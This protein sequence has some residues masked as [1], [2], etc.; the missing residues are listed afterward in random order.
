[1]NTDVQ[2]CAAVHIRELIRFLT[3]RQE[4]HK[5]A[6]LIDDVYTAAADS[7]FTV[8]VHRRSK[9]VTFFSD[10]RKEYLLLDVDGL[11]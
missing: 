8:N 3:I 1:M 4:Q 5:L 10:F 2:L 7:E 11:G 9:S 6:L